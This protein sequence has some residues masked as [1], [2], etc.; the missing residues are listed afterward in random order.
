MRGQSLA[1]S[2]GPALPQTPSRLRLAFLDYLGAERRAATR[3]LAI[4]DH[5]LI[6]Y[7]GFLEQHRAGAFFSADLGLVT[8][9]EIRAWLA[10][11]RKKDPP[12]SARTLS[13][14]LS[15][16]RSFHKF[17]DR[18]YDLNNPQI[19]LV[20]GP[21]LGPTLPRPITEDQAKGL[22]EEVSQTDKDD[23]QV[24]RDQA[25][26]TLLYGCGLRISEALSLQMKDIPL[27]ST[28]RVTGKGGKTRL[29]PI[30]DIVRE[31][32]NTY[33][34]LLPYGLGPD[35]PVFRAPRGG[36]L[37]ARH[38]AAT[39][40]DLR[41]R[42]GL[43]DTATPHALRHSF[44]THL[45]GSGADLKSIQDLLGHASLSTTQRYTDVDAARL[46]EAYAKAHPKG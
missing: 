39:V 26:L 25:V 42:L 30:L 3:T 8:A 12:L 9:A 38:V 34:R 11:L 20:Q 33:V 41:G 28:W 4:Y 16:M 46:L 6:S 15:A 36:P 27:G 5:A 43:P 14:Y 45:L 35:E 31:R 24:A 18:R 1:V 13:L 44:A 29:V 2:I 19:A 37:S 32:I 10:H 17:L 21:R 7:L 40:Q 22:I 23:W